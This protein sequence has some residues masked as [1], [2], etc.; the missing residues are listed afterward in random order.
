MLNFKITASIAMLFCAVCALSANTAQN[1]SYSGI[2]PNLAMK[3]KYGECGTGAVVPYAGKLW[4][5]TYAPHIYLESEDRLYEI[6]DALNQTVRA[7]SVGG[8]NAN[9]LIHKETQKLIIGPYVIDKEG[10]VEAISRMLMPGRLTGTAR[11]LEDPANK[12]YIATMEEGL[13][14][15]DLNTLKVGWLIRDGNLKPD[16]LVP[17][18]LQNL[19]LPRPAAAKSFEPQVSNLHGYH[20]KGLYSGQG[21]LYYS[22]NGV[23]HKDVAKDPTIPSGALAVWHGYADKDWTLLR[24]NQ[25]TEITSRGGIYGAPDDKTPLWA[26]GWDYRSVLLGLLDGGEWVFFR[27]PKGSHS[28]DGSHGWNTEWPRIREIGR[29]D[30]LLATMHGTF[31]RFPA[32]FSKADAS[33]IRPRSNYLKVIGDFCFWKDKV[34]FGCDDSAKSE[35]Y[36][37]RPM[38]AEKLTPGVSNSNLW[39]VDYAALDAFGPALGEGSVWL[40]DSV[41]GGQYSDPYLFAGYAKRM[42]TIFNESDSSVKVG[43]QIDVSGKG[44]WQDFASFT[45]EP[46]KP[47]YYFFNP[48]EKGEWIRLRAES[49]AEKITAHFSYANPDMRPSKPAAIFDGLAKG[50]PRTG[51]FM[52]ITPSTSIK[53]GLSAFKTEGGKTQELGY[54]ELGGDMLLKPA[55]NETMQKLLSE[56]KPDGLGIDVSDKRVKFEEDGQTYLLPVNPERAKEPLVKNRIAREVSTERDLL[57]VGGIFYELPAKNAQGA[58]KM[59]AVSSCPYAIADFCSF[60]G[61]LILSGL[62]LSAA[63]LANSHI[64]KSADGKFAVWAGVIDDLWKFGKPSGAGVI[65]DNENLKAKESSLPMLMRGFD[66]KRLAVTSPSPGVFDIEIDIDGTGLWTPYARI[67]TEAGKPMYLQFPQDFNAYFVRLKAVNDAQSVF[68]EVKFE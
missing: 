59:R 36:N 41:N 23:R 68:A 37:K 55:S 5:I 22:N 62:E 20:G 38:K 4:A 18:E 19:L 29:K 35:F 49:K 48:A 52:G 64:V 50:E 14:E 16:Y 13:Y 61:M 3:N 42:M 1:E 58:S 2:Y 10:K 15:L 56:T 27:L 54:Y 45:A 57:Y 34:V 31:W 24:K 66:L 33:G 7:E 43:V 30:E 44:E 60:R 39:F 25:F 51:A 21:A 12:V 6:D 28:Y 11:H 65:L 26:L 9:R 8:T 40:K 67:K 17:A 53:L 46:Q 63:D 47:L 32:G